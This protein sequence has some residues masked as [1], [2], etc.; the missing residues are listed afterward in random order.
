MNTINAP[1]PEPQSISPALEAARLRINY[2]DAVRAFALLLGIVFHT[3]LSFSPIYIGWAVMDISTSPLIL[4]FITVSHSFRM[5]LFFLI[6]GF[7][8]HM[9]FHRGGVGSFAQ[10][11]VVR[12]VIPFVVGWF[13]LRPLIV[14]GWIMGAESMQGDVNI[15][16]G[17]KGGFLSLHSLPSELL[18]G[19]HLWFL[20]YMT[21]TTL[22]VVSLRQWVARMPQVHR[23][24]SNRVD[25]AMKWLA[26]S[27]AS[28][29]LLA[30]PTAWLIG[31]MREWGMD[32]PDKSLIPHIPALAVYGG[33]FAVGWV[34]HRQESLISRFA[35][36][37]VLKVITG[38]GSI[39][40][41]LWLSGYQLQPSHPQFHM[42]HVGYVYSY[43]LMMWSLVSVTIGLFKVIANQPNRVIRYIADSSYWLYLV[44]LPI[45]VWLQI[46]FAEL[47]M[48]WSLKLVFISVLTIGISILL[49]D[50]VVRSTLI[51]KILNGRKRERE[52]FRLRNRVK[53]CELDVGTDLAS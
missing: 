46:A 14:S 16:A 53:P 47:P 11:R 34:F 32:T 42:A 23:F 19:T 36:L 25:L 8:S 43:S 35:Q 45:V 17:L 41:T 21:L 18:V 9:S 13:V 48:H 26:N 38:V 29:F 30:L 37:S 50:L 7:F 51:G 49:Y 3:S 33:F 24:L 2:L 22:S 12:I 27:R 39:A 40:A 52:I 10:S 6:A 1:Q 31:N 5:E 4:M 20:Y 44:H 28:L 15:L